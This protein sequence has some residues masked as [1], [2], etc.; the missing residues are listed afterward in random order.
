MRLKTILIDFEGT[1]I[2]TETVLFESWR[3]VYEIFGF[4]LN[5]EYWISSIRP[6][7]PHAAAY[8]AM[9]DHLADPPSAEAAQSLQKRFEGELMEN[10]SLR[11]G[12]RELLSFCK[13]QKSLKT[14]VVS[15]AKPSMITPHLNRLQIRS[16]IDSLVTS[17]CLVK[18]EFTDQSFFKQILDGLGCKPEA[19]LALDDA[20]W[21]VKSAKAVGI[22]V[23]AFPNEITKMMAFPRADL[24]IDNGLKVIEYIESRLNSKKKTLQY[25]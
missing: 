21:G 17:E 20:P 12:M 1:L 22:P 24:T 8:Y 15:S 2:D 4:K 25:F 14:V 9:R 10:I 3:R 19:V 23:I 18:T 6:D 16:L 7:R 13:K 11:P 5:V